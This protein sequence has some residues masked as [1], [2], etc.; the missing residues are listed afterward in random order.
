MKLKIDRQDLAKVIASVPADKPNAEIL[1]VKDQGIY[2][3][4][5]AEPR[6]ATPPPGWRHTVAYAKGFHPEKDEDF[7]QKSADVGGDDFG[8]TVGTRQ[9]FED[10]L[11]NSE[12]DIIINVTANAISTAYLPKITEAQKAMRVAKLQGWI[13]QAK[14][15]PVA[16]WSP[17]MKRM[18]KKLE[19]ELVALGVR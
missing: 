14:S 3:M 16:I 19:K 5:G 12:G 9:E 2:V 1:I 17:K 7:W 18:V 10:I 13:A 8:E 11:A 6:P 15:H 4:S